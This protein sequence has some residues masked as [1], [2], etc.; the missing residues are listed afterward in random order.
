MQYTLLIFLIAAAL[1]CAS[2]Y[3]ADRPQWTLNVPGGHYVGHSSNAVTESRGLREAVVDAYW[4]LIQEHFGIKAK[5]TTATC[6]N[7]SGGRMSHSFNAQSPEVNITGFRRVSVHVENEDNQ[8]DVWVLMAY[9][10]AAIKMEQIKLSTQKLT[11]SNFESTFE[12][13]C[14]MPVRHTQSISKIKVPLAESIKR[15]IV[16]ANVG[17][18]STP[19]QEES[20]M[21]ISLNVSLEHKLLNLLWIKVGVTGLYG[22]GGSS[23]KDP[24]TRTPTPEKQLEGYE[25]FAG[26]PIKLLDPV[27][28]TPEYGYAASIFSRISRTYN[29]RG[30]ANGYHRTK[31]AVEQAFYG[32]GLAYTSFS[33]AYNGGG[34]TTGLKMKKYTNTRAFKGN[35]VFNVHIGILY[36]F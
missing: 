24:D 14:D 5:F 4:Q 30:M 3:G 12:L 6:N 29:D 13:T 1:T 33:K 28:I 10:R 27:V 15:T 11:Y 21:A 22:S 8:Y 16:E 7:L 31:T 25:L 18:S 26:I 23:L 2:S 9:S 35:R 19:I 32:V 34:W 36:K 20:T 17:F